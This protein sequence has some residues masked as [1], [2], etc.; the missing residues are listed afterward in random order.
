MHI[1]SITM[2]EGYSTVDIKVLYFIVPIMLTVSLQ[3]TFSTVCLIVVSCIYIFLEM[4][5]AYLICTVPAT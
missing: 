1:S 5:Q 4:L 3:F 2:V